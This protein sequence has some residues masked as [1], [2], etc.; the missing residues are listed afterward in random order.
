MANKVLLKGKASKAKGEQHIDNLPKH[1]QRRR[2][3]APRR[4]T[5]F[6][7]FFPSSSSSSSPSHPIRY[8]GHLMKPVSDEESPSSGIITAF[9]DDKSQIEDVQKLPLSSNDSDDNKQLLSDEPHYSPGKRDS[10]D[11]INMQKEPPMRRSA[12]ARKICVRFDKETIPSKTTKQARCIR[13]L[14]YLGLIA[15]AGSPYAKP[16]RIFD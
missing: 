7:H 13:I 15:P 16:T 10:P 11:S 1:S 5:D 12:R 4:R 3:P 6:S 8:Q 9:G 14:R 2:S